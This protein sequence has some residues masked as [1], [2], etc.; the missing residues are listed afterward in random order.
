MAHPI[1][2]D[3]LAAL[4]AV[5]MVDTHEHLEEEASRLA[6]PIDFS[7]LFRSYAGSDAISAGMPPADF[8]RFM[9]PGVDPATKWRLLAPF[10]PRIRFT[11]YCRALRRTIRDIYGFEDLSSES[12]GP[13]SVAMQ[14]AN[15][16]GIHRQLLVER[17]G[18]EVCLVHNLDGPGIVYRRDSD[19]ALYLQDLAVQHFLTRPLP[20]EALSR[21]SGLPAETL[22]ELVRLIDHQFERWGNR[23]VAIKNN[24]AYWRNLRFDDV[25]R[26][27]AETLFQRGYIDRTGLTSAEEKALQDFLFHH[28]IQRALDYRLP[29]KIHTGYLAGNN[30]LDPT[31]IRAI[32]LVP[33][34]RKY[35]QARFDLFHVGYPYQHEVLALTK[36]YA[37]VTADLCWTWIIDPAASR[38]FVRQF[39]G[40]VPINK[41]LG[42]GGDYRSADCVYGH[43]RIA[44][45]GLAAVLTDM[46]QEGE[47]TRAE[48]EEIGRRVLRENAMEY[49]RVVEKQ[50]A[51]V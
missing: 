15:Q 39:L 29:I 49:F 50:R 26:G 51:V 12:V 20:L 6:R 34:F 33:L 18:V 7:D 3:I 25:S 28:C 21:E 13:L 11:G 4:D 46:L 36:Q 19:P 10:W 27:Q 45:E 40:A 48:A 16:P 31:R 8:E 38:Q 41:L 17:A 44:R 23:A 5:R 47:I 22:P 1:D 30:N 42:F 37:N 43:A 2:P 14:A 32:D 35:P 9:D 24:C